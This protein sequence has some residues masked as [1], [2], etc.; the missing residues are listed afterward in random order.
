VS[1][2]PIGGET[3][4]I[5]VRDLAPSEGIGTSGVKRKAADCGGGDAHEVCGRGRCRWKGLCAG[6]LR[7]ENRAAGDG[8]SIGE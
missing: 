5:P 7:V 6:G 3:K 1:R 2:C 4:A 8:P